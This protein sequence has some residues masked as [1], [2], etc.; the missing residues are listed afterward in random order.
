MGLGFA[1][2]RACC[3][4][5]PPG[6]GW[7]GAGRDAP[8]EL[9]GKTPGICFGCWASG[10]LWVEEVEGV[11]LG[12]L[13]GRRRRRVRRTVTGAGGREAGAAGNDEGQWLWGPWRRKTGEGG[14]CI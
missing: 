1:E 5:C 4:L 14:L 13:A 6:S 3:L 11:A 7:E 10:S 8:P 2:R 12:N 9:R